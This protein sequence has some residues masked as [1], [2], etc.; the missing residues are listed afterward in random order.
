MTFFR[1]LAAGDIALWC[2]FWLIGTP[3]TLV[4]DL[5]GACTV[6]GCGIEEPSFG[7]FLLVLFT[8]SSL[9]IPVV[10]V[11]IWRSAS[12][13]P[14]A[15]WRQTLLAFVAKFCAAVSGSLAAVG[16]AVLLYIVVIFIYAV[17]DRA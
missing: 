17:F 14:R 3:L 2:A 4:W 12:R 1:R 9:A 7:A 16:V 6:V 10:S 15:L 11:A 8:L 13:Y 5:S